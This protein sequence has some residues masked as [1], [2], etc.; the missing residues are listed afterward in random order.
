V[1]RQQKLQLWI[2]LFGLACF[3]SGSGLALAVYITVTAPPW[4]H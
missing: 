4:G 1:N 3:I 2:A